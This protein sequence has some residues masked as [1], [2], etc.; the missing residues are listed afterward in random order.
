MM[1]IPLLQDMLDKMEKI[2]QMLAELNQ[3]PSLLKTILSVE[4]VCKILHV[5]QRTLIN[6]DRSGKLKPLP[7][8]GGKKL[9]YLS[10]VEAF[11]EGRYIHGRRGEK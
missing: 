5:C 9:Y 8:E 6:W 7:N 4:E 1:Q 10:D 11:L 2:E 3:Q